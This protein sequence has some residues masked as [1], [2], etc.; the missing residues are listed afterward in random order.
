MLVHMDHLSVLKGKIVSLRAEIAQILELNVQYRSVKH[1]ET[2]EHIAHTQRHA[3]LEQ[4]KQE[5]AH[6]AGLGRSIH[7]ASQIRESHSLDGIHLVKDSSVEKK[8]APGLSPQGLK[9][10]Y[11]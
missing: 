10:K 4:I 1:H 6:L 9:R 8:S 3:R 5:L 7:A 2:I 11:S